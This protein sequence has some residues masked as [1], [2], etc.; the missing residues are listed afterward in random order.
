MILQLVVGPV[1]HCKDIEEELEAF[2]WLS[3]EVELGVFRVA[4]GWGMDHK[5]EEQLQLHR[6][7]SKLVCSN[8]WSRVYWIR[9]SCIFNTFY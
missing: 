8:K 5:Q 1:K 7:Q 9:N 3:A 6:L 2:R 4:G